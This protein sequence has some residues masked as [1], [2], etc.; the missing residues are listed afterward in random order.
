MDSLRVEEQKDGPPDMTRASLPPSGMISTGQPPLG[1]LILRRCTSSTLQG[2]EH[3]PV[4][5]QPAAT[6]SKDITNKKTN[7]LGKVLPGT[8]AEDCGYDPATK[9]AMPFSAS[10]STA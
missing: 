2:S 6:L 7:I 3:V 1:Y 5:H 10:E 8:L 9:V 4:S